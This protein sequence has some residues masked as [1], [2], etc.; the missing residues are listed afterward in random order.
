MFPPQPT[1]NAEKW[2]ENLISSLVRAG[3]PATGDVVCDKLEEEQLAVRVRLGHAV[4]N[5][6]W[7]FLR[8]YI[9]QYSAEAGW[10][11]TKIRQHRQTV[12]FLASS[13]RSSS[14]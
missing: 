13:A 7:P 9:R 8:E 5:T 4:E 2:L 6:G 14:A 12:A 1:E 11:V 10:R 3:L